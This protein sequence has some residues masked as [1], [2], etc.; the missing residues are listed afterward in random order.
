MPKHYLK[1]LD[2]LKQY[3]DK[4]HS[5]GDDWQREIFDDLTDSGSELRVVA[6]GRNELGPLIGLCGS[7]FFA[8]AGY[9][10]KVVLWDGGHA[11]PIE[12]TV[13]EIMEVVED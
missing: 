12:L 10:T 9:D 7:I 1:V 8:E 2:W 13:D 11:V 4:V 5:P 3:A 6:L